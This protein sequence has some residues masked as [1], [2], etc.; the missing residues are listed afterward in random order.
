MKSEARERGKA[1]SATRTGA[2]RRGAAATGRVVTRTTRATVGA[3]TA[4]ETAA[5]GSAPRVLA[6]TPVSAERSA[7]R[8]SSR[9]IPPTT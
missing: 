6:P 4:C 9:F 2:I 8:S 5:A 3:A 1:G 7:E